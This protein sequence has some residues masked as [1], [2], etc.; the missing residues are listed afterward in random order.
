MTNCKDEQDLD[1]QSIFDGSKIGKLVLLIGI[2][3]RRV[4][5]DR[6]EK[7]KSNN[8]ENENNDPNKEENNRQTDKKNVLFYIFQANTE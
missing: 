8:L 6:I 2:R 4:R 1:K 3:S 7:D 5:V